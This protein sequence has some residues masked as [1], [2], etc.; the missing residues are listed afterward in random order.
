MNNPSRPYF[1]KEIDDVFNKVKA[2]L[3]ADAQQKGGGVAL[4]TDCYTGKT[5]RGGEA[6]DYEHVRSSEELFMKYRDRMTNEQIAEVVNCEGNVKVTL[7]TINQSKGKR[8]FEEWISSSLIAKFEISTSVF[9][10]TL[11][12]ADQSIQQKVNQILRR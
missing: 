1:R 7:R 6:Y 2:R 5:L 11:Q 8:R 3:H 10:R 4:F 12:V 9:Q